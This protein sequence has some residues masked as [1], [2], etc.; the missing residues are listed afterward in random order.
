MLR[1]M[2]GKHVAGGVIVLVASL[3]SW[4]GTF[5]GLFIGFILGFIGGILGIIWKPSSY[6]AKFQSSV[7]RFCPNCGRQ[8]SL[9]SRYCPH[10]GKELL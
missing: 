6:S 3:L 5:G 8:M 2:P 1:S 10:C 7:N 4:F 9:D